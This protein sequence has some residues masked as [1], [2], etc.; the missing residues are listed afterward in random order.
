[1]TIGTWLAEKK[2]IWQAWGASDHTTDNVQY[3]A[4]IF[5]IFCVVRLVER[6][7]SGLGFSLLGLGFVWIL[8][9]E[10]FDLVRSGKWKKRLFGSCE[11][12]IEE[13]DD[14]DEADAGG[15]EE[16]NDE[17]S[18]E[19]DSSNADGLE[20]GAA[21]E[22]GLDQESVDKLVRCMQEMG[23]RNQEL[24]VTA[25]Q[26]KMQRKLLQRKLMSAAGVAGSGSGKQGEQTEDGDMPAPDLQDPAQ[27]EALIK[28]LGEF[29]DGRKKGS[30]TT[31]KKPVKTARARAPKKDGASKRPDSAKPQ[32]DSHA[33]DD[34]SVQ[35]Q[36][37][38][39]SLC[40]TESASTADTSTREALSSPEKAIQRPEKTEKTSGGC[41]VVAEPD[42]EW[43]CPGGHLLE[44]AVCAES[45]TCSSCGA[46]VLKGAEVLRSQAGSWLACQDCI[47]VASK[48][49]LAS[50]SADPGKATCEEPKALDPNGMTTEELVTWFR[51]NDAE[52][53]LRKC[54]QGVLEQRQKRCAT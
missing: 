43:R 45:T 52:D 13:A 15:D 12:E 18:L 10:I 5:L 25:Q 46:K 47:Q 33:D 39:P 26:Q 21:D 4:A 54:M 16:A 41:T 29:S 7:V 32:A 24:G 27:V 30:R 1:M 2:E 23:V 40:A 31:G 34:G 17:D 44:S 19:V 20:T 28:E 14:A 36:K 8:Q 11:E 22:P 42:W 9:D 50:V 6:Q 53:E 3:V 35:E 48:Q 37:E 49:P 38:S 51:E